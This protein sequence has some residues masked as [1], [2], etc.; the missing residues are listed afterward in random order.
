[1]NYSSQ[2]STYLFSIARIGETV[3]FSLSIEREDNTHPDYDITLSVVI[4]QPVEDIINV[5]FDPAMVTS[6]TPF[7]GGINTTL[8]LDQLS[9]TMNFPSLIL[10]FDGVVGELGGIEQPVQL[11]GYIEYQSNP[12]NGRTYSEPIAFPD[13][14]IRDLD[15]NFSLLSTSLNLTDGPLVVVNEV[16]V[17]RA[18][19]RNIVGPSANLNLLVE[20]NDVHMNITDAEI[21]HIG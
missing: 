20:L 18:Q 6:N 3:T 5:L 1:M 2:Y 21:V 14:Y 9:Y 7:P 12:S 10:E 13:L 19:F 15:F 11:S 17:C 4:S 8:T 16:T